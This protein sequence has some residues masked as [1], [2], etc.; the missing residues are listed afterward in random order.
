MSD[1]NELVY[2]KSHD[3]KL[4][5]D[6]FICSVAGALFAYIAQ[7]YI[8][9]KLDSAFSIIQTIALLFLALS[10]YFG[11]RRIQ[12]S[13]L[14]TELNFTLLQA[15]KGAA[16]ITETLKKFTEY[17]HKITGKSLSR[18]SLELSR[19]DFLAQSEDCR[20]RL[21]GSKSRARH[22]GRFQVYFLL[23]GF[24]IIFVSKVLQ[25][26]QL[27]FH[28]QNATGQITNKSEPS[29]LR[30]QTNKPAQP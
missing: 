3:A 26:Y 24:V 2:S 9:Q 29:P 14:S 23:A 1:A 20:N 22:F 7:T 10:F 12:Y 4:K 5:F 16:N 11:I 15:E 21:Q 30:S 25:P 28:H 18:E 6:Y 27:G 17:H 8:P 13:S 19:T